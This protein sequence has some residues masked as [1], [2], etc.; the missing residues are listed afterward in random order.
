MWVLPGAIWPPP[1]PARPRTAPPGPPRTCAGAWRA[2]GK[3]PG[4][5]ER[6]PCA[7]ISIGSAPSRRWHWRCSNN[8]ATCGAVASSCR[9]SRWCRSTSGPRPRWRSVL[10]SRWPSRRLAARSPWAP[11]STATRAWRKSWRACSR[12]RPRTTCRWTFTS[13]RGSTPTRWDC[14]SSPTSHWRSPCDRGWCAG[15][16]VRCRCS[17]QRRRRTRCAPATGPASNW[18]L[19]PP[20]TSIFRGPGTARRSSA[21]SRA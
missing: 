19:C 11:L 16:P 5:A 20:P 10:P 2:H 6:A 9:R 14:R 7:R 21:A 15:T 8:C 18:W 13:T 3:T 17:P 4:P 1:S 12:W